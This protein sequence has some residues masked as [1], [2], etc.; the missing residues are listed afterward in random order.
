MFTFSGKFQNW[1]VGAKIT[2]FTFILTGIIL[3]ALLTMITYTTASLLE[4]RA[5]RNTGN[6]LLRAKTLVEVFN[7]VVVSE[8]LSFSNVLAAS[9]EGKFSID[10]QNLI[11][12]AG[13]PVPTL[14]IADT[15]LNMD[16]T[17]VDRFTGQTRAT[18]TVFAASGD[19]FIR[20]STSVKKEDGERAIGTILDRAHAGY[21]LLR[22]GNSYTGLATLFGKQYITHYDP[23]KDDAGT[24]IGVLYVGVDI[25]TDIVLLKDKIKEIKVGETGYFYVLNAAPGKN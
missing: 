13:K 24:V 10:N 11:D 5:D 1:G 14:K 16:F 7:R 22:G 2:F 3:A 19:D 17:I 12:V 25:S 4:E 23:I 21:A 9:F 8:A 18:A 15:P 6:E 20:I